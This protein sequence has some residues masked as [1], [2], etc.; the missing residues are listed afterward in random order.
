MK[1][2]LART[3][4]RFMNDLRSLYLLIF[5]FPSLDVLKLVGALLGGF[6]I[7]V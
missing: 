2:L 6:P 7:A 3:L 5:C 1:L 4:Y